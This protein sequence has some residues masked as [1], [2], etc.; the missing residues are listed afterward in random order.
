MEK[1][2]EEGNLPKGV[3]DETIEAMHHLRELGN[4]GA[5]MSEASGVI[6][7][8]DQDEALQMIDLVEMLFSDWYVERQARADRLARLKVTAESKKPA[9]P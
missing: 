2:A 8:V 1:L 4:I 6:V 9:R 5:H 7:D 3:Q